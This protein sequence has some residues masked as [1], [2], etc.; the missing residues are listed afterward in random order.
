MVARTNAIRATNAAALTIAGNRLHLLDTVDGHATISILADDVLIERNTLLLLPF[1]ERTT[2]QPPDD[3]P[4]RDPSDPCARPEILYA[5]PGL[6]RQYVFSAWT[7]LIAQLVPKQPYRAIGGIHVR[8]GSERVRIL[9]ERI[10][11]PCET[12]RVQTELGEE[13]R[14]IGGCHAT[15]LRGCISAIGPRRAFRPR[16]SCDPPFP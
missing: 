7:S 15:G 3:D 1:I 13:G 2:G 4:T 5:F 10:R 11:G 8:A 12:T 9:G 16:R 14:R 6:V